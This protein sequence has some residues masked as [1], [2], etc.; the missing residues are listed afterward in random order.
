MTVKEV[1][2]SNGIEWDHRETYTT[3]RG[4]EKEIV[5]GLPGKVFWNRWKKMDLKKD[6][7]AAGITLRKV[8]KGSWEVIL[9]I[10]DK[11]AV[12]AETLFK[13]ENVNQDRAL[14]NEPF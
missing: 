13:T 5:V 3:K 7:Y 12:I 8:C 9:W 14:S 1:I 2:T 10:S 11:N 6:L 4:K